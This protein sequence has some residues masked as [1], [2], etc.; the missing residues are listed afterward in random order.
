MAV[1]REEREVDVVPEEPGDDQHQVEEESVQVVEEERERRL[2]AVL[3]V[4]ELTDR[5]RGRV[6]EERAVVRLA[7]VVAGGSKEER[8]PEHPQRRAD[9][10]GLPDGRRIERRQIGPA[11]VDPAGEERRPDRVEAEQSQ[12]RDHRRRQ[13]PPGC[14]VEE[15]LQLP[16]SAVRG[17]RERC[18]RYLGDLRGHAVTIL[19]S[20]R[21][22]ATSPCEIAGRYRGADACPAAVCSA[23]DGSR[24]SVAST[25]TTA[26]TTRVDGGP[27]AAARAAAAMPP[28]GARTTC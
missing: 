23:P 3:A 4:A 17:G 14:G 15:S 20:S 26:P 1:G 5:A 19:A 11:L 2:T 27:T 16:G 28:S 21:A 12:H 22:N 6:P 24:P 8:R 10:A 13:Q 18:G 9:R 25:L 7:V